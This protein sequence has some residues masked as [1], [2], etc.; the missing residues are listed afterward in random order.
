MRP[1]EHPEKPVSRTKRFGSLER[2]NKSATIRCDVPFVLP[3]PLLEALRNR[4]ASRSWRDPVA[5]E[6]GAF[7]L[8]PGL[9]PAAY[10]MPDGRVLIDD[11]GIW[12]GDRV[13]EATD[14]E[15]VAAIVAGA[16]KRDLPQLLDVLPQKPEAART[17]ET[18]SGTRWASIAKNMAGEPISIV[19]SACRGRGWR[20]TA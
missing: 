5:E 3:P 8:D 17:C 13:R 2:P 1:P 15:A 14:D 10:L 18:C 4:E 11:R 19:C 6:F 7:L 12:G 9:G 20:L 16:R